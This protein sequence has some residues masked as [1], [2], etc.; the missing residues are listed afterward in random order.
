MSLHG[1]A[2]SSLSYCYGEYRHDEVSVPNYANN[3]KLRLQARRVDELW[4]AQVYA[5]VWNEPSGSLL[6]PIKMHFL[7][8]GFTTS[9]EKPRVVKW[10]L[11]ISLERVY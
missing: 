7:R 8:A 10:K 1:E 6:K 11:D 9:A 3:V 2:E 5:D 4:G